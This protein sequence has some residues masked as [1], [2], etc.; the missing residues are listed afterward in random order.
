[1]IALQLCVYRQLPAAVRQAPWSVE[2]LGWESVCPPLDRS[3]TAALDHSRQRRPTALLQHHLTQRRLLS[4]DPPR[5]HPASSTTHSPRSHCRRP[6]GIIAS[7]APHALRRTALI[8]LHVASR[9]SEIGAV[10]VGFLSAHHPALQM[11]LWFWVR[12]LRSLRHS[13][14]WPRG[15]AAGCER[16]LRTV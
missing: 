9:S 6:D 13:T 15:P 5:G 4:S 1:M 7:F 2:P 12:S 3:R 10:S 16:A 8:A 14:R 11:H